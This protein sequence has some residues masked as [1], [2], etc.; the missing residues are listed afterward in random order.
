MRESL[1]YLSRDDALFTCARINAMVCGFGPSLS[2]HE[3][4]KAAIGQLCSLEEM[5]ALS[6]Y[7]LRHGGPERV[8]PF[9]RGQLL[10]LAR[11]IALH[12][13]HQE[14]DGET[15]SDS[16]VRSAFV[17]A[18]LIASDLWQR[19]LFGGVIALNLDRDEQIRQFMGSFRKSLE[20]GN[21]A[22]HPGLVMS[23]G[24][25]LFSRYVPKYMTDF[26]ELFE[27]STNLTLR[28]YFICATALMNRTF[29]D[30][31]ENGRIFQTGYVQG[32]TSFTEVFKRF[33][34]LL[35]Q[36]P[37][38]WA[39]KLRA[40]PNDSGYLSLRERP[41][42]NFDRGRSIIFDP[43]FYL[44]NL[45][46]A[47]IFY[48]KTTGVPMIK[49]FGAFGFAFEE[50]AKELLKRRFPDG[51]GVLYQPLK[52]NVEG[53]NGQGHQ[54]EIDAVL[55][56]IS[57]AAFVEIKAALL[58]EDTVLSDDPE[59]FLNE[60]RRKYGHVDAREER[61]KGVAQLARSIG[62]LVRHEWTGLG[63]EYA[64]VRHI[65][66][67]LVVFD[68]R[69]AA[70]G[71]CYFL[72]SEFRKLLGDVPPEIRVHPLI[73]LTIDDLEQLISGIESLSLME[74]LRAYSTDDPDRMSSVHN[75]IAGSNY[76]NQVR[77][78]PFLEEAFDEM[79]QA[80]RDELA[81]VNIPPS[82]ENS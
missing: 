28:Q 1:A 51:G 14:G 78:S 72:E 71:C 49:V 42:L 19:R 65:Y 69:M 58:R 40:T 67:V 57:A 34:G 59:I 13:R 47:P 66:P 53:Q 29:S 74:F 73:V 2:N 64:D 26:A 81:P 7:A 82:A 25:I 33:I 4:Q 55:N 30:H 5:R 18:A 79:M 44:E 8:M 80:V 60:I 31:P 76:L 61:D 36:T 20:E 22:G 52:C 6:H 9:F 48:L 75:F 54:F 11:W 41:I 45:T 35:S 24:W 32:T 15:F 46:T 70:P 68:I 16:A 63:G 56:D 12:C 43:T 39:E 10:E 37:E 27:R 3:R 50:Y 62:A 77:P 17:R 23:R 38:Q 21:Q